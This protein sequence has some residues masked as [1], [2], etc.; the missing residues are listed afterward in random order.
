MPINEILAPAYLRVRYSTPVADHNNVFYFT[1]TSTQQVAG[2][3]DAYGQMVGGTNFTSYTDIVQQIY[4]RARA[5]GVPVVSVDS[6]QVWHS[7][8]GANLFISEEPVPT[9]TG[10]V[11]ASVASAYLMFVFASANRQQHRQTYF[12]FPDARPQRFSRSNPPLADDNGIAWYMIRSGV[13]FSTQDGQRL[14][15][16]RSENTGYNRKLARTY[17][18]TVAP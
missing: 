11:G 16:F 8:P 5:A 3:T 10:N 17:G 9:L 1:D 6:V 13:P 7:A 14:T 4:N 18:R 15:V 2:G 12:E